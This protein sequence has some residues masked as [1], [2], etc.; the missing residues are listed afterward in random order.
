MHNI[1]PWQLDDF[2]NLAQLKIRLPSALLFSGS[3]STG[4]NHLA[5]K[6]I[7]SILCNEPLSNWY[8]CGK[9]SSCTLINENIH[10]DLFYLN[11][12]TDDLGKT[13]NISV[14]KV[15]EAIDFISITPNTS[16]TKIVFIENADL[17]TTSSANALLKILEEPPQYVAFVLLSDNI[18]TVL[19]TIR[20]R[21][22][23]FRTTKPSRDMSLQYLLALNMDDV[24]DFW[25]AFYQNCPIFEVEITNEQLELF[26]ATLS[27]PSID[28]IFNLTQTFDGKSVSFNFILEFIYKWICDLTILANNST[29]MYFYKYVDIMKPLLARLNKEKVFYLADHLNF[30]TKWQNHPLNY[31]LQIENLL[32]QYQMIF[33]AS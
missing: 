5:M 13:K 25:L 32:F 30:L 17:L 28:N 2:N 23:I 20:S 8:Q 9:C 1:Y 24:A 16:S 11:I 27:K 7:A 6:F 29:P 14:A 18:E 31:K 22:H 21:C 3:T 19:P 15:R 33:S 10:P 12:D 26:I 4:T